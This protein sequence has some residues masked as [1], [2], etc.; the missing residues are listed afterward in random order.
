[1]PVLCLL[2]RQQVQAV[3]LL[4]QI[5]PLLLRV[6]EQVPLLLVLQMQLVQVLLK[7]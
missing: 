5:Q 3:N 1:M 6:Q 7:F 4:E 2:L